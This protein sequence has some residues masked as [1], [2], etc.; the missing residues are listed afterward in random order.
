VALTLPPRSIVFPLI[1]IPNWSDE[2][3]GR[4]WHLSGREAASH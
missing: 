1:S 4:K 2:G 3:R